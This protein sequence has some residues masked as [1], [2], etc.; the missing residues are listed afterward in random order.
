MTPVLGDALYGCMGGKTLLKVPAYWHEL[1]V[2][3]I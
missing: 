1:L 2:Q 3:S